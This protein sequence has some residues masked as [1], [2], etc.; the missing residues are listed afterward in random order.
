MTKA[1]DANN[2]ALT[3]FDTLAAQVRKAEP[4]LT[5]EQAF[6]KVYNNPKHVNLRRIERNSAY[7]S[8]GYDCRYEQPVQKSIAP[9][10]SGS[11]YQYCMR[12]AEAALRTE[13]VPSVSSGLASPTRANASA[14]LI[15]GFF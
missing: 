9:K 1:T 4:H 5:K 7:A 3:V 14:K 13:R 15:N 2:L 6:A 10:E 12:K 8:I 11:A